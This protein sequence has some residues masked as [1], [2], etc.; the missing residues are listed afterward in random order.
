MKG[1]A[2]PVTTYR[3]M[4]RKAN[5]V[6]GRRIIRA[7]LPHLRLDAQPNLMS[8]DERA[9]ATAALREMADQLCS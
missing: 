5:L 4:D 1:I 9:E 3:V 2:Y 7:E 6:D 8:A